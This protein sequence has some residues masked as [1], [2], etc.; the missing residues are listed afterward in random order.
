MTDIMTAE[1]QP[2][3]GQVSGAVPPIVDR[4]CRH[5]GPDALSWPEHPEL[6]SFMRATYQAHVARSCRS[7]VFEPSVPETDLTEVAPERALWFPPPP[8]EP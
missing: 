4:P 2:A 7:R 3:T 1:A 5:Y 8:P 6:E